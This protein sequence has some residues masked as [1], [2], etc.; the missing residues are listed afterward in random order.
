LID[1][2]PN[3]YVDTDV[4]VISVRGKEKTDELRIR[5]YFAGI[6]EDA[7]FRTARTV[8]KDLTIGGHPVPFRVALTN[9]LNVQRIVLHDIK[10]TLLGTPV[11]TKGPIQQPSDRLYFVPHTVTVTGPA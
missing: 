4:R 3:T 5:P 11:T 1:L 7:T 2:T 8:L 9:R 6:V 10:R